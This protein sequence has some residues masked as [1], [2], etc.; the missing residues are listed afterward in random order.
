[1]MRDERR[2]Q[3]DHELGQLWQQRGQGDQELPDGRRQLQDRREQAD[4]RGD[5]LL[6]DRGQRRAEDAAST[7]PPS[8]T[9]GGRIGRS[10]PM[11]CRPGL[12]RL[13]SRRPT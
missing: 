6:H 11:I 9:S 5:E 8:W 13:L 12:H 4:E 10:A 1:M 3:L 2:H 7:C